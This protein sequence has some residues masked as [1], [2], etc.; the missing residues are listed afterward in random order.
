M[1]HNRVRQG[2]FTPAFTDNLAWTAEFIRLFMC[3]IIW[4]KLVMVVPISSGQIIGA[5]R[6]IAPATNGSRHTWKDPFPI[7][8]I[9]TSSGSADST[10]DA[11]P[12]V[13][14]CDGTEWSLRS[15]DSVHGPDLQLTGV[16]LGSQALW[17][18]SWSMFSKHCSQ[19]YRAPVSDEPWYHASLVWKK[20][21]CCPLARRFIGKE[22]SSSNHGRWCR[23]TTWCQDRSQSNGWNNS[24][25]FEPPHHVLSF[26]EILDPIAFP[27][28]RAPR[29]GQYDPEG[30]VCLTVVLLRFSSVSLPEEQAQE[31]NFPNSD[32][33]RVCRD[34]SAG[35]HPTPP[36]VIPSTPAPP[37][38][39]RSFP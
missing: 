8:Y 17:T 5:S 15:P 21:W 1:A 28:G 23:S 26:H 19:M 6:C 20:R 9:S 32:G 30:W 29:V 18:S 38:F 25:D 39:A 13:S 11:Y 3:S 31:N 2:N 37:L 36:Q 33:S 35:W 14:T 34:I 7:L 4:L 12:H 16:A 27:N 10:P 22:L 24:V